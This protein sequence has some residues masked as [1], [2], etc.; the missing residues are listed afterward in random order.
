[1]K[2]V[3]TLFLAASL[4]LLLSY[5]FHAKAADVGDVVNFN[6]DAAFEKN[7]NEQVKA[8]LVKIS[9]SLYFYLD[10]TWW[11]GQVPAKQ[12]EILGNLENLSAEF[13]NKIY[14]TLTS[15]FGTEWRPGVDGDS[16]IT[17]LLHEMKENYGGYYRSTD[18]YVKIQVPSS[19]EREMVFLPLTQIDNPGK[20]KVF[21][22]H[23]F[24]HMI[25][26]NQKD[27]LRGV[28]EDVWLN[29]ARAEYGV[30]IMGYNTA[31]DGSNLQARVAD[32]LQRPSDSLTEWSGTKY[33]YGV[34]NV[35]MQYL[36][37]HYGVNII[38][39][40]LKLK[41]VGIASINEIL[42]KNSYQEDFAQIFTDWTVA[43]VVNNCSGGLNHCYLN[44]N[45]KNL[46]ISPTLNFL[47]LS[48]NSSLTVTNVTKNW[49]GNWQKIIG[50]NGDLK[51]EFSSSVGI[52]FKVPYIV[53]DKENNYTVNFLL[54]DKNQKGEVSIKDFGEKYNS[55]VV[56]PLLQDKTTGFSG[57]EFTY[58]YTFKVSISGQV[59]EDDAV[60]IAQL[61]AQIESL[62][63][64]IAAI[65]AG[66][67]GDN[68]N[69]GTLNTNLF[70]GVSNSA[71]V[72]CLQQFFAS[73]GTDIYPEALITGTF[74]SLTRGA[75]IRF[76]QKYAIPATGY[77]GPLT[78]AKINAILNAS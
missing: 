74:G 3:K 27:R 15:V 30:H 77:V 47:P 10:K 40:S 18:E 6:V 64:Q 14:P 60:V 65:L 17:I 67:G 61:L 13:S 52:N 34:V 44:P 9:P 35:F 48:G 46:R 26:F 78:R 43:N 36:V 51:L 42:K 7:E 76:Q 24:V 69:C 38:S 57:A 20:L 16:K 1:M 50:G 32:F 56:I 23:E 73:Q 75:A 28:Q 58:P 25:T 31:Y 55:L 66:G 33:D 5:G 41:S 8:V 12:Q 68:V 45:I 49:T 19:N 72:K 22:A 53:F 70:V 59:P 2:H 29:E 11:D 63:K 62:K 4:C 54:L 21:L 39:D 71:D 37:D